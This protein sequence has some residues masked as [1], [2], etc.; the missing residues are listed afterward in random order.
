MEPN[1]CTRFLFVVR[2]NTFPWLAHVPLSSFDHWFTHRQS[3]GSHDACGCIS[4]PMGTHVCSAIDHQ[5]SIW[6]SRFVHRQSQLASQGPV[7]LAEK[8]TQSLRNTGDL[9]LV[10]ID[11]QS[12]VL[13][14]ASCERLSLSKPHRES[15]TPRDDDQIMLSATRG[16]QFTESLMLFVRPSRLRPSCSL[17]QCSS[18]R[19]RV[20]RATRRT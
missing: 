10:E 2:R 17:S 20:A 12:Y 6:F 8:L 16:S 15:P 9:D 1:P 11:L 19:L 3:T 4:T 18:R 5:M 7:A 14:S 13:T